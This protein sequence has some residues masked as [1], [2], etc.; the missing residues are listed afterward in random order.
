M[1]P[2]RNPSRTLRQ[3]IRRGHHKRQDRRRQRHLRRL[4]Q[5]MRL[6]LQRAYPQGYSP[7]HA[8]LLLSEGDELVL[9]LQRYEAGE[10]GNCQDCHR[11]IS[12]LELWAKPYRRHCKDCL[13]EHGEPPQRKLRFVL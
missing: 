12:L 11:P 5:I 2:K 6:K 7:Q 3:C 4:A 13:I 8:S 10:Y 9:A 1:N